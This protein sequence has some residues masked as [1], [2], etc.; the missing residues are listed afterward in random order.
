MSKGKN[1]KLKQHE[2]VL[3]HQLLSDELISTK[4]WNYRRI[5]LEKRPH[6][7]MAKDINKEYALQCMVN[8]LE[9]LDLS[10]LPL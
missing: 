7:Q 8:K 6:N 9:E 1:F 4:M 5:Q 3:L 2:A 10:K